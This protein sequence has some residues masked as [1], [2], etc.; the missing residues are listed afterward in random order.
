MYNKDGIKRE[1]MVNGDVEITNGDI[2]VHERN[3]LNIIDTLTNLLI[4]KGILTQEEVEQYL[5]SIEIM[6]KLTGE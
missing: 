5:K 6:N 2:I 1:L 4:I 3:L